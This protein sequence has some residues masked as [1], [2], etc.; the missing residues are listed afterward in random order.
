VAAFLFLSSDPV[1]PTDQAA[2]AQGLACPNLQ[3]AAEAY[4]RGDRGAFEREIAEAAKIAQGTLDKSG[5]AFGKPERIAL[6][7]ELGQIN[8]PERLLATAQD[9]CS[10]LE[11][12][13]RG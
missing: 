3:Q 8:D 11:R 10:E 5:Q 6:E 4:E 9:I 1:P 2:P 12:P 13:S 7:L